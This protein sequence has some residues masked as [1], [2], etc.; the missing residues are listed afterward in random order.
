MSDGAAPIAYLCLQATREGQGSHAHVHEIIR[1]LERR[2]YAVDLFEPAYAQA[3]ATPPGAFGRALEFRRIQKDLTLRSRDA[4]AVYIRAHFAAVTTARWAKQHG[5]PVIQ[6]VN[7]PYEDLFT[8]WPWTRYFRRYFTSLMRE[9][10]RSA[11]V[12]ITVTD[13][14]AA[15]LAE[16]TGRTD[17]KVVPNGANTELFAPGAAPLAG[18]PERYVLFFG[19]FAV[20]QGLDTLMA[21]TEDEAWPDDVSLLVAGDGAAR[22]IVEREADRNPRVTYLGRVP[23]ADVP[24]LLAG[25]IAGLSPQGSAGGHSATGLAPQKV[26]ETLACGVPV[27]VT[28]FP[29]QADLVREHDLGL[30][31]P[32]DDP[33]AIA[34]AVKQLASDPLQAREMGERGRHVVAANHSWDSRAAVTARVLDA[35]LA[36]SVPSPARA[37]AAEVSRY[38][39]P[40]AGRV[41]SSQVTPPYA[42]YKK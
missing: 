26:Y 9:Q 28:D 40:D 10:Y 19:A 38:A 11:D 25:S 41:H 22:H 16:E 14:L 5:V 2:G 6:E 39:T 30:V 31:V 24:R 15:W 27:V 1:G 17:I 4:V 32:P 42:R 36:C 29:G 7:G 12:V 35:V 13:E 33:A 37:G 34:R 20:W 3:G 8:A 18:M 21:A 23:Y